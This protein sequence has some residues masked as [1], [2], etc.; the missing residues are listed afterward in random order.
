MHERLFESD[1][2]DQLTLISSA[3]ITRNDDFLVIATRKYLKIFNYHTRGEIDEIPISVY[4]DHPDKRLEVVAAIS[5]DNSYV[6]T[7]TSYG[8]LF[9]YNLS[10]KEPL[11]IHETKSIVFSAINYV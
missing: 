3:V 7:A 6:I 1:P 9:V 11:K 4:T 5:P 10:R 8:A 2:K